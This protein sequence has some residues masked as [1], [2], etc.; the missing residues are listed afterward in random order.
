MAR[1]ISGVVLIVWGLAIFVTGFFRDTEGGAYGT[2]QT[3]GWLFSLGLVA[4]G[5]RAIVKARASRN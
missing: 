4:L 1:R 3:L 5:V 2:G